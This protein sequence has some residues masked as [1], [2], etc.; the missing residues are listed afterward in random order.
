MTMKSAPGEGYSLPLL[1]RVLPIL[2]EEAID[3]LVIGSFALA[4]Y[5]T[6]RATLDIDALLSVP[7]AR[8][9]QLAS[10]LRSEGFAVDLRMGDDSDSVRGILEVIDDA[11]GRV[12]LLGGLKGLDPSVFDRARAYPVLGEPIRFVGVEDLIAMKCLAG[13]P[14]DILDARAIL[15]VQEGSLDLDLVRSLTRRF[16]RDA[17][18]ALE[19]LL[20]S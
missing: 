1:M 3:Y 19:S 7:P 4:V 18:R 10:R 16:G 5:A 15:E 8:L 20:S 11:G 13:G 9:R 17:V 6:V 2:K 12:D 14:Q